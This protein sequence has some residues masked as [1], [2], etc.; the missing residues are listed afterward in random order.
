[1][2]GKRSAEG[3]CCTDDINAKVHCGNLFYV[4][5]GNKGNL[6]LR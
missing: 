5:V 6:L 1:M 3:A 2:V 4:G